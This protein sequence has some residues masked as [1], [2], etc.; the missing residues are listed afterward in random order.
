MYLRYFTFLYAILN[1][2][3]C[4]CVVHEDTPDEGV[5]DEVADKHITEENDDI[6]WF[7]FAIGGVGI[8]VIIAR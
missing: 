8:V 1:I 4:S 3:G 6:F 7:A 5:L 2:P